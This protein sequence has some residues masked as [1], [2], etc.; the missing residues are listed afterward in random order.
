MGNPLL[1]AFERK[2]GAIVGGPGVE[3]T[4]RGTELAVDR[5]LDQRYRIVE[6]IGAGGS[7]QVYLGQDTALGREVAIKVLDPHAAADQTLRKLFVKEARALAQLSHPNIVGVFD[8][9]EVDGLPFIVME[10]VAGSSLK[11]RIERSGALPLSEVMKLVEGIGTGLAFAHSRGIIHADLKPSNILLDQN[12]RPKIC[13]FGIA[14][15]PAEDSDSPQLFATALYVAPERVEG[16][17]ATVASD[18]YGLGLVLYEMLVGKPPF[19]SANAAVLLRDHVVRPPV[20]PSH[21][22]PSLPK[23]L[24]A[25]ALKALA[26]D[27]A[28]RYQKATEL[29]EALSTTVRAQPSAATAR[30]DFQDYAPSVMTEPLRG[31]VPHVEQSPVVALLIAHGLPIRRAFYGV[32]A[33][34][35]LFGL[36]ILAGFGPIAAALGAGLVLVAGFA[37]QLGLALAIGWFLETALLFLFVPG[38]AVIWGVLGLWLWLRDVSSE[39][40]AMAIAMPVTAPF[41][42]APALILAASAIHGLGGVVTVL[43]GATI[44]MVFAIASGQQAF[45]AFVQTGLSFQ[46]ESVF[47]ATRATEAKSAVVLALQGG[48]TEDRFGAL[49]KLFDPLALLEQ[50]VGLVSR[51]SG[52]DVTW[53]GTIIAWV[54]AA[55]VVW[56]VTR[57]LRSFFDT[58]LRRSRGWFTLYVFAAASGVVTGAAVLYM[59]FVT[60]APLAASRGRPADGILFVAGF[61][62]AVMAVA[63][64]VVIS[65]TEQPEPDDRPLPAMAGRHIAVR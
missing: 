58:I 17:P 13:D 21:L 64:S 12:D 19:T 55:L 8:V 52:A 4:R 56:T 27:P 25:I 31:F 28:L 51:V 43:W 18:V 37:G 50:M 16:R 3:R 14:R 49:G 39:R 36:T 10:Y 38:L 9:G 63:V 6:P 20:P 45:G 30:H 7:S 24:D 59:L 15:T 2:P 32:L 1:N 47:S 46:Q 34:L 33:A 48:G 41:G 57:L 29:S 5:V 60:W 61:V 42:L 22:R 23:E 53:I 40:T 62:G 44:T 35:P 26:K 54:V 65:A 11:Q